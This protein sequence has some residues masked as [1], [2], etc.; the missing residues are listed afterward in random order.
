MTIRL[1]G[2]H[3]PRTGEDLAAVR[4][5]WYL[6]RDDLA[7]LLIAALEPH[8]HEDLKQDLS[9]YQ[10][11]REIRG[12]LEKNAEKRNWWR[13]AYRENYPGEPSADEVLAW[14][15]SQVDRLRPG[16]GKGDESE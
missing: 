6:S 9:R 16:A 3:N 11:E 4:I 1:S 5:T 13:D 10:A 7:G 8:T 14:A 2:W 15:R 12:Q